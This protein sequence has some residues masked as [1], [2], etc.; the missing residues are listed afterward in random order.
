MRRREF[1]I[2]LTLATAVRMVRA[3]EP[4]KQHRI[5]IIIT[6]G[7]V[8]LISDT[9]NRFWKSFFEELRRLGHVEGQTSRSSGTPP[10][11]GPQATPISL[12]RSSIG[13]RI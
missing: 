12:A 5:A 13:T 6:A 7:G 3:Q 8:A 1:T 11:G 10:R 4:A 2:G 9:G